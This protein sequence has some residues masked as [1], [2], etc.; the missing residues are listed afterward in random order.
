MYVSLPDE[1]SGSA[2][3]FREKSVCNWWNKHKSI[4]GTEHEADGAVETM[5]V[6]TYPDWADKYTIRVEHSEA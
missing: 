1:L 5:I 6:K 4:G 3:A 2:A